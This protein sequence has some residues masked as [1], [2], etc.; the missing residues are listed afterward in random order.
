M[1][2][3]LEGAQL[4]LELWKSD[5]WYS[6]FQVVAYLKINMWF[7]LGYINNIEIIPFLDKSAEL[8]GFLL[9]P[10]PLFLGVCVCVLFCFW[11]IL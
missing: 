1:T 4:A 11:L 7:T 3:S 8:A 5:F 10:S 6:L 2:V 9:P